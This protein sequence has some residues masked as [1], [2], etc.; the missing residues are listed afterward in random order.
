MICSIT[1]TRVLNFLLKLFSLFLIF[2][3]IS[4]LYSWVTIIFLNFFYKILFYSRRTYVAL[5]FVGTRVL[6]SV[7][8]FVGDS[9]CSLG[10]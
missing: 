10:G 2:V 9:P 7:L 1:F 5:F 4:Y 6:L 3:V 8:G